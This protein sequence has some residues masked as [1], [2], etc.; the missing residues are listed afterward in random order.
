M[1]PLAF[2]FEWRLTGSETRVL[3]ALVRHPNGL[4]KPA[5][6]HAQAGPG[7]EPESE[8]KIVDV[9]ICK[10][11][12]K[13]RKKFGIEIETLWDAGYRLTPASLA[14]CRAALPQ[15]ATTIEGDAE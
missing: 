5:L 13:L 4:S 8:L 14:A 12:G 15:T 6:H 2:P 7:R 3:A 1:A 11:R 9:F 10:I